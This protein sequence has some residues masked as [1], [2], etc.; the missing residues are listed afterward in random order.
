MKVKTT[1]YVYFSKYAWEEKGEY[2]V[3]YAKIDDDKNQTYVCTQEVELEVPD[4]YDPQAQKI[5][6]LEQQ[7][8]KAMADYQK[9]VTEINEQISKLQAIEYTP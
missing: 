8:L 9:T 7:K 3:F 5:A 2:L 6:A 4:N 1:V